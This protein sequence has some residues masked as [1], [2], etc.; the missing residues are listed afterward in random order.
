MLR[1]MGRRQEGQ[2]LVLLALTMVA[3]ISMLALAVDGGNMYLQR[4][5]MQTA[6]D[7]GALAGAEIMGLGG[8]DTEAIA[9]SRDYAAGKNGAASAQVT[10]NHQD[11]TVTVIARRTSQT[12]LAGIVGHW[13]FEAAAEATASYAPVGGVPGG[14]FPI[15]IDW[16]EFEYDQPYDLYAGD[17]PGNFGWLSWTGCQSNIC[18]CESLTPPGNSETYTNPYDPNDHEL[19]VGDWVEGSTAVVN[20]ACVRDR[21]DYLIASGARVI[22]PVWNPAQGVGAGYEY[23][24]VGFAEFAL[25]D[26]HLPNDN[27]ITGQFIREVEL[28]T[29]LASGSGYGIYRVVL[30]N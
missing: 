27:R 25:L 10:V 16:Q 14:V 28:G 12:F 21:L 3:L 8:N 24:I 13:S 22:I 2:G 17:G 20:S 26:Y 18:L 5:R 7:A 19:N 9:A 6:A 29:S 4:R 23:N 15:A 30:I 11:Q 1:Q